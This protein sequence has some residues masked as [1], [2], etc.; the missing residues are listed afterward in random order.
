MASQRPRSVYT[1]D[2]M[3]DAIFDVTENGLSQNHAAQKHG[4][5]Q[6]S[7]SDRFHGQTALDDQ[8]QPNRHLSR[9][10]EANLAFWIFRQE[11]LGYAPSHGQIRACVVALLKQ[12]NKKQELGRNWVAKFIKRHPKLK[13]KP[14][15]RQEANRFNSFTPKAV[16]WYFDIREEEYG[17]IK[18]ENTVNVDEGGI[19]AAFGLDSLVVGS[20]DPKRKALLKGP[21]SRNWTSFI[22]AITADGRALTPGIIFKGKELQK[23]WFLEEFRKI[24]DWNYIT[25]PNGWTDNHIAVEW[26]ERVY[27]PQTQPADESDA[28]LIILDGHGSHATPLDNGIFN[29]SKAAYRKELEK[30]ASL[31]DSAPVD[32]AFYPYALIHIPYGDVVFH[33]TNPRFSSG[34]VQE[35]MARKRK[36]T[37]NTWAHAR[38]PLNSE[39][40]RCGRKNEKIYYCMHCVSPTYSTTVSTTFRNHLLKTHG[41]ELEAHEHPIK[42]RRDRLI[43]DAFA[44][45]G[46]MHA[47]KQLAK[48]EET[49]RHAINHKAALEALIQLVTVR[50]LSYNCSSWPELHALIS[51]VNPAADD[52]I[53]LSHG[54]IQK[55]VSNSFRVTKTCCEENCSLHHGNFISLL[56]CDPDAKEAL[57]ALLALSELPGLDGPGSHGGA[58]QWK[59]LQHVLED[60]NIWNKVGFYTGD[61]HGS[62]GKL[63]RLL[64]NYLQEK[65]VDWEAKTRR[66]RCHGHIVNLA[67][68]AFLFIDS[69]EAARAALEHI[70]DTDESA[71]GTDFSERIKPQRAQGW[72][73]LGP[74]GK[75][76]NISIHMRENDYRWNEF[77]K[78]AGRSLGLDNDTRWNSW[79]LLLDTTLNLQSY[80]EWYQKKYY[81]DLR[82]DYL[83]PDEWSALGET[84]AFLQ[85][86]WKITQLTEGRYATLDRS[87]FTM[88]VLHKHYTQAFQKHSGNA[89]LRSCI[90]ASWAVFDKYYQ[91]TDESPAYGAAIILHPSRRVAHIKKN[92]PKSWHKPV[93]DGVRK[94]WKDYYHELPLPTTTPQLRDEIRRLDEYDLLARELDVVSPSM[95]ELDEY[96]AFT[97]QPP[98]AID[99]SP[100]SWWLREEQQQTY[101]R[102]SRMA[103]DILS[104]PAQASKS[105]DQSI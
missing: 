39:P 38:E 20:S 26:L 69:K 57:Q 23:Q 12:Q 16:H 58:E 102:L 63:C 64:A 9:N 78:R 35:R 29:A 73:R 56:T 93:L 30:L 45:A 4:I 42:K 54:S 3:A 70:E 101:P 91:L 71:F 6:Q 40:S 2:E 50:N 87:L 62:N 99:C 81:Q 53:S 1:E 68:Q 32:Q 100:L 72:R 79:F 76:H 80:V 67:V 103:V 65:G 47:A 44:K 19:M 7:I 90:A 28:R 60:Y 82:D 33:N 43:Q 31:T 11:S 95:S 86:F 25:S 83:T 34:D 52:L 105:I 74:L 24:A 75:V 85:P 49:L 18:P 13:T 104:I 66:I 15:R 27:L 84:R 37:A 94:H 98:I 5:P 46:D 14:G 97:T 96:D 41:I 22:E 8:V 17:W 61:N 48:R 88:D 21:Q 77:K 89:T 10:Q 55:L 36:T 59:L 92:W 51:A